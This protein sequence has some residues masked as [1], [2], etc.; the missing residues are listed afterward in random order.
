MVDEGKFFFRGEF[1]QI[2]AEG[3][4]DVE[5]HPLNLYVSLARP[6]GG[7]RFDLHSISGCVPT[8]VFLDE[9]NR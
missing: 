7:Q 5:N 3:M 6:W 9:I 4:M 8:R 1:Y 2:N